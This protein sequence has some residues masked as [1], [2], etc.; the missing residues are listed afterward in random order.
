MEKKQKIRF[1]AFVGSRCE[2]SF[3]IG[4]TVGVRYLPE[5]PEIARI[6][7]SEHLYGDALEMIGGGFIFTLVALFLLGKL[8]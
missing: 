3:K 4:E 8:F 5:K 2:S 7:T 1:Q 6:N